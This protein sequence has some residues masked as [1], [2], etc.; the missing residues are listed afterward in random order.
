MAELNERQPISDSDCL[1]L[2]PAA[3]LHLV[4]RQLGAAPQFPVRAF[5]D[6]ALSCALESA[7]LSP[8][9]STGAGWQG[10]NCRERTAKFECIKQ[11]SW[12]ADHC[13]GMHILA[14]LPCIFDL[15]LQAER[16]FMCDVRDQV[17][18]IRM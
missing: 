1:V 10:E 5:G 17:Q 6:R 11:P 7:H 8:I 9:P 18:D 3:E 13:S 2:I 12:L 15:E 16:A 4:R 14:L